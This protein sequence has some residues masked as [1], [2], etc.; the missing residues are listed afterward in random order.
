MLKTRK[1]AL[2]LPPSDFYVRTIPYLYYTLIKPGYIK[3]P[4]N[5]ASVLTTDQN[6]LL[7]RS[8]ILA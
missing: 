2:F 8:Q 1:W 5:K 3:I 7:H 6:P 4:T